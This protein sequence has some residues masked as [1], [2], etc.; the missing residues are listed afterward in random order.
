MWYFCTSIT[1]SSLRTG[2]VEDVSVTNWA[3]HQHR[4]TGWKFV[5]S[6]SREGRISMQDYNWITW[7]GRSSEPVMF[8]LGVSGVKLE[9]IEFTCMQAMPLVTS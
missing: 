4:G 9:R 2:V 5:P 1:A 3:F 7:S 6:P 8:D